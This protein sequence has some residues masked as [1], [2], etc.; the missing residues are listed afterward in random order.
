MTKVGE[1]NVSPYLTQRLRT[2]E[3]VQAER[4]RRQREL[5]NQTQTPAQNQPQA[6]AQKDLNSG[7]K[8]GTQLGRIVDERA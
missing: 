1:H 7:L 4:E 2:I 3:E 5:G 6:Q 8:Q